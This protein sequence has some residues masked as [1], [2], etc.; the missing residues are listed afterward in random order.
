MK[1]IYIYKSKTIVTFEGI[2]KFGNIPTPPKVGDRADF[3]MKEPITVEKKSIKEWCLAVFNYLFIDKPK[4]LK[5]LVDD[6][7]FNYE[8]D[9]V[10]IYLKPL[11]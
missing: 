8:Q 7:K 4:N 11:A 6:V 5:Y 3:Y 10:K 2:D 1:L 9:I